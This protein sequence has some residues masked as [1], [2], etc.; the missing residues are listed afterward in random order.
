MTKKFIVTGLALGLV[1]RAVIAGAIAYLL[2][3]VGLS[4]G[5]LPATP[6]SLVVCGIIGIH[7]SLW[8]MGSYTQR[9]EQ[10]N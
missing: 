7:V 4:T 6:L 1:W 3:V 9:T 8:S 2:S 10:I 5:H